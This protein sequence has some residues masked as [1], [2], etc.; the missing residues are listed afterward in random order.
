MDLVAGESL[1]KK[2]IEITTHGA[3][4]RFSLL[5]QR[6]L[7]LGELNYFESRAASHRCAWA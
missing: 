6:C 2:R 3:G 4:W 5:Y 1:I 7:A